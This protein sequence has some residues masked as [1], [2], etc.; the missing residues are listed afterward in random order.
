MDDIAPQSKKVLNWIYKMNIYS[1]ILCISFKK[2]S[3]QSIN[4]W[5][6]VVVYKN[7]LRAN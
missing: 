3:I 4:I 1:K 6:I 5:L 7:G 2:Y